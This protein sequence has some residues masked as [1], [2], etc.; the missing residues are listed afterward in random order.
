[1]KRNRP[2]QMYLDSLR[3]KIDQ[4]IENLASETEDESKSIYIK[5]LYSTQ[6]EIDRVSKVLEGI[7]S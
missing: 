6:L 1:M 5:R 2:D 3:E 7:S 4:D